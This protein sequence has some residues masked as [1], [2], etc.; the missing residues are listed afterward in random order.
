MT[1][2]QQA[3]FRILLVAQPIK[4]TS[5]L[6]CHHCDVQ[7]IYQALKSRRDQPRQ[8]CQLAVLAA[9][10]WQGA[11]AGVRSHVIMGAQART[12]A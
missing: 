1:P 10:G 5:P 3:P 8:S 4:A 11:Q 6:T 7:S 9:Q 12:R 2:G